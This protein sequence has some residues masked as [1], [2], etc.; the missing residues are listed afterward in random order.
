MAELGGVME[1]RVLGEAASDDTQG[2]KSEKDEE[3]FLNF[4]IISIV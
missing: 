2:I 4:L 3:K 1:R